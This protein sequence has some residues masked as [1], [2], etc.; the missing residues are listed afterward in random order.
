MR[1]LDGGCCDLIYADPPFGHKRSVKNGVTVS[2]E[3]RRQTVAEGAGRLTS[4]LRPRLIEMR[5]L[6]STR[7][8]LCVHLDWHEVH[9]V[10]VLLDELFG[11]DHFL[12]EII[13]SYR[14]GGRP[15]RWLARKHDTIL[16]YARRAGH[17]TFNRLHDGTYR[18]RDLKM[19][20]DGIPYKSARRGRVL[21]HPEGPALSDVW[22]IPILSTVSKERVGRA[23]QKPEAL[24]ERLIR[25]W[26]N[27]NDQ[28]ADFFCG[29]GTTLV[30]A[31]RLGRRWIG[32]DLDPAAVTTT[33]RRLDAVV[34][35][36]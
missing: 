27:A 14:S 22:E 18:T 12:N 11:A 17:H 23:D 9:Y 24:L 25:T 33:R 21:F 29:S 15:A 35:S 4:F 34:S 36:I 28:V 13:W 16:V 1:R 30:V 26:S 2:G 3:P 8:V 7:G 10:K 20:D 31:Q 32:C 5:R 19:T 6:L